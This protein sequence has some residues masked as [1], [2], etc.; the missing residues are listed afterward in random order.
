DREAYLACYLHSQGLARTGPAGFA[1]GYA[2][3]DSSTG[4]GWPDDF[5]GL[6]LRLAPVRP[7]VVY[8]TYHYRVRY[9]AD[10]QSGL[11]ERLFVETPSGWKIAVTTAFPSLAGVAPPPRA[12]VGATLIDG[13]GRAP[14]RDAVI[15]LRE[16]KIECA[17]P[18]SRCRVP[19]GI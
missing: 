7:G 13:T 10:E 11:S 9:G 18:R 6:D 15:V 4:T 3:L 1:L 16:G 19:V 17:G 2:A 14:V 12:I 8:G 5:E